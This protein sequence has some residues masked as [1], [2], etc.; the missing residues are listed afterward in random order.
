M[1]GAHNTSRNWTAKKS[2][3]RGIDDSTF[4]AEKLTP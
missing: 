2:T 1:N 4:F 3:Q